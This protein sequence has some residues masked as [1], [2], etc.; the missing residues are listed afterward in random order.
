MRRRGEKTTPKAF[1]PSTGSQS[2]QDNFESC[3]VGNCV[4]VPAVSSYEMN[5]TTITTHIGTRKLDWGRKAQ[6]KESRTKDVAI[7]MMAEAPSSDSRKHHVDWEVLPEEEHVLRK[8]HRKLPQHC[9]GSSWLA[10]A[11]PL[12]CSIGPALL[13][14]TNVER[15]AS[16]LALSISW[17]LLLFLER[18]RERGGVHDQG[19][20]CRQG[21][22][23]DV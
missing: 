1:L 11:S 4:A 5:L 23:Y 2:F 10:C 21:C 22:L 19:H 9:A 13:S 18:E 20:L 14:W 16:H 15:Q 3:G 12:L 7:M 17:T 8:S 6:H